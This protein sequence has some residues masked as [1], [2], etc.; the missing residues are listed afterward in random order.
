[1]S[2]TTNNPNQG[3]STPGQDRPVRTASGDGIG[4]GVANRPNVRGNAAIGEETY[5]GEH[6]HTDDEAEVKVYDNNMDPNM[7][8]PPLEARTTVTDV[9]RAREVGVNTGTS[10]G[11]IIAVM[12][13]ILGVILLAMWLL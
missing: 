8:R 10:W 11:T 7:A 13:I 2:P 12:A 9:D 6:I 4:V 3:N 5:V 1:M